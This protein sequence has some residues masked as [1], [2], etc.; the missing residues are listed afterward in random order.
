MDRC[1]GRNPAAIKQ[2]IKTTKHALNQAKRDLQTLQ[3]RNGKAYP[4]ERARLKKTICLNL[5]RL[6]RAATDAG[7][8][9]LDIDTEELGKKINHYQEFFN[10]NLPNKTMMPGPTQHAKHGFFNRNAPRIYTPCWRM[11]PAK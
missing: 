8:Q 5:R 1:L 3:K 2:I 4:R 7:R 9:N 10:Q 6:N 11:G